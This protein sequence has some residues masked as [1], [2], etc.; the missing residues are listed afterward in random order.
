MNAYIAEYGIVKKK[1]LDQLLDWLK[2][3]G[4]RAAVCTATDSE[5]TKKYLESVGVF[6]MF[7]DLI[8]GNMVTL[9]KPAP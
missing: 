9:G 6:D 4:I 8:C 2:A 5:R 7:T 1:G 3:N